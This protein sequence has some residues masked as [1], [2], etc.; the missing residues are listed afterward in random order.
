MKFFYWADRESDKLAPLLE[1]AAVNGIAAE[2]IGAGQIVRKW[3]SSLF[4]QR[5][6]FQQA[7]D[8]AGG[9]A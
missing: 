1:S 7:V 4:K 3:H 6:L 2:A 8:D 9:G 5:A